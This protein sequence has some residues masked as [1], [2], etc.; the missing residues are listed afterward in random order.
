M[1]TPHRQQA[2]AVKDQLQAEPYD[3]EF[4]Q[5][6][7]ILEQSNSELTHLGEAVNPQNEVITLSSRACY[8]YPASDVYSISN[9]TNASGQ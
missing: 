4:H 1:A 3:Y 5:A 8:V 7:R 6:V 9:N 2:L